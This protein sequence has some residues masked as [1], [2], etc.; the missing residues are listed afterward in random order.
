MYGKRVT[1]CDTS[2]AQVVQ[3]KQ[4]PW[5]PTWLLVV[6]ILEKAHSIAL[7]SPDHDHDRD[8]DRDRD[9]NNIWC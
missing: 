2:L 6:I 1:L 3:T 8:R 7:E 9:H 5:I 4:I